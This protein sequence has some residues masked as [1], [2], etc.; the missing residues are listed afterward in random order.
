M[1]FSYKSNRK[2]LQNLACPPWNSELLAPISA[3]AKKKTCNSKSHTSP[4][5]IVEF[6]ELGKRRRCRTLKITY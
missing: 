6:S 2:K 5:K 4:G 1:K 3:R